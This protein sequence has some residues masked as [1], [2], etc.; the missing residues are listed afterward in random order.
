MA[1]I[2]QIVVLAT[3]NV[4]VRPE[5]D[6]AVGVNVAPFTTAFDGGLDV[7]EIV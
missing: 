6:V 2:E 3:E 1:P 5:L 4:T 7:Y